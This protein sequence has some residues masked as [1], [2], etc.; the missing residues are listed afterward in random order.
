MKDIYWTLGA[1]DVVAI[2]DA[3]DESAMTALGLALG[4][5][6]NVRTP[7]MRAFGKD[8]MN[9]MRRKAAWAQGLRRAD[10]A[11]R[12]GSRR[13]VRIFAAG[14]WRDPPR[15]LHSPCQPG[16]RAGRTRRGPRRVP[17]RELREGNGGVA[18]ARGQRQRRRA[19]PH[20]QHVR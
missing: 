3:P 10:A 14:P 2:F 11:T 19:I 15:R 13:A 12:G 18:A 5:E 8:G 7:T 6:G 16:P 9:G 1:Y 17:Q 4:A 20:R